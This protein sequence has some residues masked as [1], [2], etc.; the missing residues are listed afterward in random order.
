[1]D[2]DEKEAHAFLRGLQAYLDG[3]L[4]DREQIVSEIREVVRQAKCS[5]AQDERCMSFP[6]G[7]FLNKYVIPCMNR[8]LRDE[9]RLDEVAAKRAL[10]S[11]SYRSHRSMCSGS[12]VWTGQH[13]FRKLFGV[14]HMKVL[15][16]WQAPS[17]ELLAK[18]CCPDFALRSPSPTSVVFEGK[19]F[20]EGNANSALIDGLY[21]CFF[22]RGLPRRQTSVKERADWNYDYA[23]LLAYDATPDA[24]LKGAWNKLDEEVRNAFWHGAKIFVLLLPSE[25]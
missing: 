4:P 11:E 15:A 14:H 12:P 18:N 8:Y 25:R 21:E 1:M 5:T 24:R 23:C 17:G 2:S 19:Y 10:L 20:R 3:Q 13:P 7:A 6:E 22:Y 9:V 16:N